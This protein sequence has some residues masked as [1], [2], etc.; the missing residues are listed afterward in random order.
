M[1]YLSLVLVVWAFLT[2]VGSGC[3]RDQPPELE[4]NWTRPELWFRA[5]AWPNG[6]PAV[7]DIYR[8]PKQWLVRVCGHPKDSFTW[9]S[10]I[11]DSTIEISLTFEEPRTRHPL[12]AIAGDCV[13]HEG[14]FLNEFMDPYWESGML[15]DGIVRASFEPLENVDF[16]EPGPEET[17][18]PHEALNR[19]RES[20][21]TPGQD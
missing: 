21:A 4:E 1:K 20:R 8:T 16:Y 17:F 18:D 7:Y 9:S 11:Q 15:P 19:M 10:I 13:G 5:K 3:A 14:G 6:N 2:S 12:T